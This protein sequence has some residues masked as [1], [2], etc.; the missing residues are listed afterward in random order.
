[1]EIKNIK[2]LEKLI[3]LCRKLGVD[4]IEVGNIKMGLG[5][6]PT[7]YTTPKKRKDV[8]SVTMP[9]HSGITENS[10]IITDELTEEQLLNWSS[11]PSQGFEQG[12]Q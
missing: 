9:D 4:A 10:R 11:A 8:T 2:D 5:P 7:I 12:E 3:K 1:M 6:T